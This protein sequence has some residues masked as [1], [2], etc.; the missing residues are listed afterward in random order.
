M[1]SN[2]P[3]INALSHEIVEELNRR[4]LSGK[5]SPA[6]LSAWL[7]SQG[8]AIKPYT[9]SFHTSQVKNAAGLSAELQRR[10]LSGT[11]DQSTEVIYQELGDL[12]QVIGVCKKRIA[13]LEQA[14]VIRARDD[15]RR[16]TK[17]PAPLADP[18]TPKATE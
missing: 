7:E 12:G 8:A 16:P 14:L 4:I 6:E 5:Y 2:Q 1:K 15:Y 3:Q 18:T 11:D 9:L 10:I 17:L 13:Q